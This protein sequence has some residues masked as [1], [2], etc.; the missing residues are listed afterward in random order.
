M[1]KILF[2]NSQPFDKILKKTLEVQIFNS[3]LGLYRAV[4]RVQRD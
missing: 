2:K 3:H 4:H 1:G